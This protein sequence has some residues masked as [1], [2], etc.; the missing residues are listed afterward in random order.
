MDFLLEE[1]Q[2][3]FNTNYITEDSE[4]CWGVTHSWS[5]ILKQQRQGTK[6]DMNNQVFFFFFLPQWPC[7]LRC[8]NLPFKSTQTYGKH[9]FEF[10]YIYLYNRWYWHFKFLSG[11]RDNFES[12]LAV[13]KFCPIFR[14]S[15]R[16]FNFKIVLYQYR[17]TPRS[18]VVSWVCCSWK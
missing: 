9:V 4:A 18:V 2:S 12:W 6:S 15:F 13:L 11:E 8:E 7:I 14:S 17:L 10:H 1:M 5:L 16:T 3:T